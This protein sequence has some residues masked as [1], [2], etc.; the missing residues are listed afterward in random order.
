[1]RTVWTEIKVGDLILVGRNETFPADCLLI[2]TPQTSI[3]VDTSKIDGEF[4]I[5]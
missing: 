1:V 2:Y 3:Y 4:G 5:K